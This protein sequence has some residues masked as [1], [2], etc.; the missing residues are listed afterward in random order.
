MQGI[1]LPRFLLHFIIR[2]IYGRDLHH[3][4]FRD[5]R[6]PED[7]GECL[8]GR[9]ACLLKPYF[10][11]SLSVGFGNG[12]GATKGIDRAIPD[13]QDKNSHARINYL[14]MFIIASYRRGHIRTG[15]NG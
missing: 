1:K 6:S 5:I 11:V 13:T 15:E 8:F 12:P 14:P 4:P 2:V 10:F 7:R 3:F 9:V